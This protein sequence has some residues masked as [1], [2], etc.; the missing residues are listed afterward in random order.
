MYKYYN[1]NVR[2]NNVNDCVIRAISKAEDKSWDETYRE[3]SEIAQYEGVL[4][5]DVEFVEHYLDKR[6][7]RACHYSKTVEEFMAE[8]PKGIYL[9]TMEGHITVI[10]DGVLYDTFD[11]RKR[12]M[13]CAWQVNK[14]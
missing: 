7:K 12:R 11:C 9:I 8:N 14:I 13:W 5:D 6:Y 10:I 3:L 1:A 2:G 4:L